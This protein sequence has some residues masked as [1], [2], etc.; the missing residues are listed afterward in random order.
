MAWNTSVIL[1]QQDLSRDPA[2][3]LC[4]LGFDTPMPAGTAPWERVASGMLEGKAVGA[5][6]GWTAVWD[7]RG[8]VEV[9]DPEPTDDWMFWPAPVDNALKKLSRGGKALGLVWGGG[10]DAYAFAWYQDGRKLRWRLVR[11]GQVRGEGGAPDAT[12]REVFA[13]TDDEERRLFLLMERRAF[14]VSEMKDVSYK[15]Y[16]IA[17]SR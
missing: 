17:S 16:T 5:K 6:D 2:G 14:P 4:T 7:P 11:A 13:Q 3:L 12:E 9:W 15:V 8:F 10:V 1:I